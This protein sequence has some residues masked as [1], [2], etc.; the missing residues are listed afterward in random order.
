MIAERK[1]VS[2]RPGRALLVLA[3]I[4]GATGVAAAAH[5]AHGGVAGGADRL[6]GAVALVLLAHAPAILTIALLGSRNRILTLGGFLIAAG[7]ILFSTDLGL[8]V[9]SDARLFANAAP[10]GGF[11]M[12]AGWL[13]AGVSAFAGWQT[14]STGC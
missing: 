12:M 9:F 10:T 6:A 13:V 11:A 2:G 3:A 5:A 14:Q 1:P 8:R 4:M 7:A